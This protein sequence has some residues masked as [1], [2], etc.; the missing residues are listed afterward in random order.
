M[1]ISASRRTD[2]PAYYSHWFFARLREGYALV[3]NPVNPRQVSRVD[4]SPRAVDGIVFWTKNPGPMIPQ[5]DQLP[6]CPYY[7]QITLTPYG[8]DV[9]PLLFPKK[10]EILSAVCRLSRRIGPERIVWRYDPVFLTAGYSA[11]FHKKAFAQLA[12]AL[13]GRTFRCMISFLDWYGPMKKR[14]APLPVRLPD[15]AERS[16]L[17]AA[18]GQ[19][20]RENGMRVF[21]CAEAADL[22]S[23]G[24]GHGCCIDQALLEQI[25]GRPLSLK[26]DRG[27]RPACGCAQSVDIG[28]YDSCPAGCLY[29]YADHG[30]GRLQKNL[31]AYDPLSS[32]LCGS[33]RPED[34][35]RE[36]KA[37]SCRDPQLSLFTKKSADFKGKEGKG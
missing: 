33:L 5:L 35:V 10:K 27:Q 36:R 3:R 23:Y 6:D 12:R 17:A 18:F 2:L 8:P 7:F 32:L 4:L 29:C 37:A 30:P 26:K 24:I 25:G 19:A 21:T 16:E 34:T 9:E 20:A 11:D 14:M 28:A 15:A 13:R 31:A 1:I 22:S